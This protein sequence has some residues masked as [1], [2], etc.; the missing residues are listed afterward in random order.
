MGLIGVCLSI[1]AGCVLGA[2][3][4][5]PSLIAEPSEIPVNADDPRYVR[6]QYAKKIDLLQSQ[7]GAYHDELSEALEGLGG[8][9]QRLGKHQDAIET[10]T[11]S[12]HIRRINDGL[13][14]PSI[15]PLLDSMIE[16]YAVLGDWESVDDQHHFMMEVNGANYGWNDER[17]L[18]VLDKLTQ[19]H[20][21]AFFEAI[22]PEPAHH[23]QMA[24]SLF[25]AASRLIEINF[26]SHDLR[27]AKQ[28]RGRRV[29]DY[30]LAS[31]MQAEHDELLRLERLQNIGRDDNY[32]FSKSTRSL[33]HGYLSGL[34]SSQHVVEI[35]KENPA[36]GPEKTAEAIAELG[37]WYLRFNKRQSAVKSYLEAY[38]LLSQR[39]D[40]LA[41][42][43]AM[44]GKP[45]V[46]DFANDYASYLQAPDPNMVNGY[47]LLSVNLTKSGA[48]SKVSYIDEAPSEPS[49]R[50]R[51]LREL[52]S[53]RF[54]PRIAEGQAVATEAMRYRYVYQYVAPPTA[55]SAPKDVQTAA[56]KSNSKADSG[57][58]KD[59]KEDAKQ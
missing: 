8:A 49:M 57:K 1:S 9:Q 24:R 33:S 17:M 15:L 6:D 10:F 28:L 53:R 31:I 36:I 2:N 7:Y 55:A 27:L 40:T 46:L 14:T 39:D 22:S 34:R 37:D 44:F 19:W 13:Y 56:A 59:E 51:A 47:V 25:S 58:P 48:V 54:R 42:R 35:Y 41:Y 30:Y 20:M 43:D 16:S 26:G 29:A 52:R 45:K 38:N 12:A 18:P 3:D 50:R 5:E 11:Q 23:L 32:R 4:A 21:Y